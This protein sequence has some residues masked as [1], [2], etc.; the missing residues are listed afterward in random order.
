MVHTPA[1]EAFNLINEDGRPR[2][3]YINA[4]QVKVLIRNSKAYLNSPKG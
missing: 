4:S 1:Y 2:M 3:R